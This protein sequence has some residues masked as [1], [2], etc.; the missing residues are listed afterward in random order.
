MEDKKQT[1][2]C[3]LQWNNI[4]NTYQLHLSCEEAVA[5]IPILQCY[6]DVKHNET[7]VNLK[8]KF[9]SITAEQVFVG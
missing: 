2:V 3:L 6:L 5:D 7:C 1:P 9:L 8:W 4:H